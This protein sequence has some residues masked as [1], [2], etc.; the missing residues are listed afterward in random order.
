MPFPCHAVP[1]RVYIVFFPFDL[2]IAAEFDTH[3]MPRPC[4]ATTLP[5]LK[6]LLKATSQR[7]MGIAWHV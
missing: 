3:A 1:L 4:H 6:R 5:F 7:G 2:H